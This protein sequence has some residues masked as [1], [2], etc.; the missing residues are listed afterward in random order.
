MTWCT[1]DGL[2]T[3]SLPKSASSSGSNKAKISVPFKAVIMVSFNHHVVMAFPARLCAAAS[4]RRVR[5][6]DIVEGMGESNVFEYIAFVEVAA[7]LLL[8][9]DDCSSGEALDGDSLLAGDSLY[10]ATNSPDGLISKYHLLT[11]GCEPEPLGRPLGIPR[12]DEL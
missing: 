10:L 2:K 1:G 6:D 12:G 8:A 7:G 9:G 3:R 11:W 5:A 4:P